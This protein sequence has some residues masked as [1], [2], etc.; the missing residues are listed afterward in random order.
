MEAHWPEIQ[1]L[2][3]DLPEAETVKALM[4][5]LDA[6]S[7]PEEIGVDKAML[8]NTILYCKEIRARY[9]L[10]QVLFDLDLLEEL[11]DEVVVLEN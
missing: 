7:T 1:A 6:P 8:R 10:L 9:T 3:R 2:L 4:Q 11:A 5:E